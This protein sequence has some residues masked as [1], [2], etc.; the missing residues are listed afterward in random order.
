MGGDGY[1]S[2]TRQFNTVLQSSNSCDCYQNG[3]KPQV[4][5]F[6]Q[7]DIE[8]QIQHLFKGDIT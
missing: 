5:Q 2:K 7:L 1:T 3:D 4:G 8:K 6:I